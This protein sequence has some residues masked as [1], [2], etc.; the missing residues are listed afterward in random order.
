MDHVVVDVEIAKTVEECGGWDA[1]DKLGVA[2]ACVWEY[3]TQR[4]RVYG[5]DEVEALRERLLKADRVT[6]YNT[7]RFDFAVIWGV[8]KDVWGNFNVGKGEAYYPAMER[9]Y[10]TS[11]DL[12]RRIWQAQ[13]FN[14]DVWCSGMGGTKLDDVAGAT[15]GAQKIGNGAD[16]PIWYQEGRVQKVVNYCADDTCIERDLSDFI[17]KYGYVIVKGKQLWLTEKH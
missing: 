2:V 8:R 6:G 17:D 7:Y 3:A 12:L 16:A 15:I 5:P 4:M 11:N 10:N 14:P 9:L 13:G 1:T